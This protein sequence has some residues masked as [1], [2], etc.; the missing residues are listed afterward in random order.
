MILNNI[1]QALLS[2][3]FTFFIA[4]LIIFDLPV[5]IIYSNILNILLWG[6]F[7]VLFLIRREHVIYIPNLTIVYSI[8]TAYAFGSILWAMSYDLAFSYAMRLLIALINLVILYMIFRYYKLENCILYGVLVGAFYNYCI[9]FNVISVSYPTI[10]FNRFTG[11]V[12]NSNKLAK[13]MLISI[14]ASLIIIA[15]NNTKTVFRTYNYINIILSIYIIVL[16]VSKLA[17]ILAPL[18]IISTLS[19]RHLKIKNIVIFVTILFIFY[20]LLVS[21]ADF[22]LLNN[23]FELLE[24]R[25]SGLMAFLNGYAGDTSTKEREVLMAQGLDVF[26]NNPIFGIGLN[27][28]RFLFVKYSHNNYIELLSGLGIIGTLLF[29]TMYVFIFSRLV[30]MSS[31]NVKR[32]LFSMMFIFLLMDIATVTYFN[33]LQLFILLYIYYIAENNAK[34]DFEYNPN[35]DT[36]N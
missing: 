29:Y 30:K 14:F 12:G 7:I 31:I 23:I 13:T 26:S 11:S 9:E 19:I 32:V 4:S 25:F 1:Y 18:L 34:V 36:N 8:F 2:V 21:Y 5:N 28:F 24:R 15:S 35:L 17:I 6:A 20:K 33:K 16:T 3:L 27:N 22:Q 10:E